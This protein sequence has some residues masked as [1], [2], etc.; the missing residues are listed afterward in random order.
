MNKL[1]E[2]VRHKDREIQLILFPFLGGSSKSFIPL[3]TE[4]EK[5][6][7]IDLWV[8]NP[9]GHGGSLLDARHN[10][11]DLVELYAEGLKDL[12][13][14]KLIF[15]G[16]SM[17]GLVAYH[18]SKYFDEENNLDYRPEALILSACGPGYTL[19]REI[20]SKYPEE[21][22]IER[23][24]KYG[25][26]PKELIDEKFLQKMFI[27]IFRADYE[28]MESVMN[29]RAD[30]K[31]DIETYLFCGERDNEVTLTSI[32]QWQNFFNGQVKLKLIKNG[33]HM[34][35]NEQAVQVADF[36]NNVVTGVPEK[37]TLGTQR[38]AVSY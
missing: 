6:K 38:S 7:A 14:R 33:Q 16:H 26:M 10:M 1:F 5:Y 23:L 9:P 30:K 27:P 13:P 31:L 36:I 25:A 34:F 24:S 17:G 32:L 21:A 4:L 22:L 35:V 12:V 3:V 2:C 29:Y 18:L 15:F 8:A 37:T 20:Y 11:K 28:V 19:D